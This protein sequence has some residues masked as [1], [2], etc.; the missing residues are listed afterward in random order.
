MMPAFRLLFVNVLAVL[1]AAGLI[2]CEVFSARAHQAPPVQEVTMPADMA[3]HDH[4]AGHAAKAGMPVKGGHEHAGCDGCENSLLSRGTNSPDAGAPL[5]FP[6]PVF[7]IP[8]VLQLEQWPGPALQ[9]G[10]PPWPRPPLRPD[11]L[12]HQNISLLI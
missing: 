8:A 3:G 7:I 9:H 12:T 6:A 11:T 2:G 1:A 4:H 10:W 5:C